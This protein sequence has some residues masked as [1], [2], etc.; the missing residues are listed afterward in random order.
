[1]SEVKARKRKTVSAARI[2]M[3]L[4]FV[5]EATYRKYWSAPFA[6]KSQC[7]TDREWV[8]VHWED[9]DPDFDGIEAVFRFTHT[10]R[11]DGAQ[12]GDSQ[13]FFNATLHAA[14]ISERAA[15]MIDARLISRET[16][17]P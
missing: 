8:S 6:R 16:V 11:N 4:W 3:D 1:M 10:A 5:D 13:K 2:E 12:R 14:G 15:G 7:V 9:P 17:E